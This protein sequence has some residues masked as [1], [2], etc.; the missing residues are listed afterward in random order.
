MS[1]LTRKRIN[2]D[3]AYSE[4]SEVAKIIEMMKTN[5]SDFLREAIKKHVE[6][7]KREEL[8][9]ELA[10]GYTANAELDLKT[11]DDFKYVDGENI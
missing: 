5:L 1:Q 2:F 8:E 4:F 9:K 11:C 6:R 3:L 10:E 7:I